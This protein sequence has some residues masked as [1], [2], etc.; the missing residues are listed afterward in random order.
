M[1]GGRYTASEL[2]ITLAERITGKNVKR[3][4]IIVTWEARDARVWSAA[5]RSFRAHFPRHGDALYD[6]RRREWNCPGDKLIALRAWAASLAWPGAIDDR[7][8]PDDT[9][10]TTQMRPMSTEAA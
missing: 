8:A 5:H 9:P 10:P 7:T 4:R 2:R 3:L 1:I 6:S